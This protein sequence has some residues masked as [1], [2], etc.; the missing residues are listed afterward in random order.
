MYG[1]GSEATVPNPMPE[2]QV[3]VPGIIQNWVVDETILPDE[4]HSY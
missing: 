4:L 2:T 1:G 3:L